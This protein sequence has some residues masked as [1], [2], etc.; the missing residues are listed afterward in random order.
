MDIRMTARHFDM[1][2]VT[3]QYVTEAMNGVARY[4]DRI[5]DQQ[6]ILT[7]EGER[8]NAELILNVSGKKLTA[9]STQ[10]LLFRAVDEAAEKLERQL[11]K[12]KAKISH[13]KD[14]RQVMQEN[15]NAVAG[16]PAG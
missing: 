9:E 8:W 6:A 5:V 1:S 10:D 2:D 14:R 7:R 15:A 4:F 11:K 3:K 16:E 13:E 12:Y